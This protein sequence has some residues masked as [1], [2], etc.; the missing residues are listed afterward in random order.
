[1]KFE[2]CTNCRKPRWTRNAELDCK[3]CRKKYGI[4]E[5]KHKPRFVRTIVKKSTPDLPKKRNPKGQ[6]GKARGGQ[7]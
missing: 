4:P 7:E 2:V 1:M 5:L 3:R 6:K